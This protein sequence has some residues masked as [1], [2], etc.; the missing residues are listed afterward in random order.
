M[1]DE[2][3]QLEDRLAKLIDGVGKDVGKNAVKL[4]TNGFDRRP[5]ASFGLPSVDR[6]LNG[7]IPEGTIVDL[8]GLPGSGK[9]TLALHLLANQVK[10]N[11]IAL[12][13][14]A[15]HK[16]DPI[17]AK[18]IG[19]DL[20]KHPYSQPETAEDAF[21][22]IFS[23][24]NNMSAGDVILVDS[25]AALVP[26]AMIDGDMEQKFMGG[27]SIVVSQGIKKV[28]HSVSSHGVILI[29]INQIRQK[30][31][32]FYGPNTDTP[33]GMALKFHANARLEVS[34]GSLIEENGVKT[35]QMVTIKT[36]KTSHC[37]PFQSLSIPLYFGKGFDRLQSE[38][39]LAITQNVINQAGPWYSY[40]DNKWQ[41]IANLRA[42]LL[43]NESLRQ[44]IASKLE[45]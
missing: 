8:H 45:I 23:A 42:T 15:E 1:P 3:K 39:D 2:A 25:A 6:M 31:G 12:I 38:L 14:D 24:S 27:N 37:A 34:K 18:T 36:V 29:F 30:I 7:G 20:S 5:C 4:V 11:K 44:E 19:L 17:L 13:V 22:I 41:G 26:K 10:N 9:T 43:E 35:G 16:I 32:V 28:L 21:D 40:G 33:C